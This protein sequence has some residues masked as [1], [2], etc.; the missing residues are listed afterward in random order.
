[1][2]TYW[3]IKQSIKKLANNFIASA[4]AEDG[5]IEAIENGNIIA[6]Q[7]HPEKMGDIIFFNNFIKTFFSKGSGNSHNRIYEGV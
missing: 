3:N 6:V 2:Q 5:T 4:I 1:M 7:W